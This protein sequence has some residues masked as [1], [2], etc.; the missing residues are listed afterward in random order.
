MYML[1]V[2]TGI[3]ATQI[4][5]KSAYASSDG[6][7]EWLVMVVSG[8][9][10]RL[11]GE[12][13]SSQIPPGKQPPPSHEEVQ[14]RWED[15]VWHSTPSDLCRVLADIKEEATSVKL[16]L[17]G[18]HK[19]AT[20]SIKRL[21]QQKEPQVYSQIAWAITCGIYAPAWLAAERAVKVCPP[22][23]GDVSSTAV[24]KL[25]AYCQLCTDQARK[26]L[27]DIQNAAVAPKN[28]AEELHEQI[29][30]V[31]REVN[32]VIEITESPQVLGIVKK[33]QIET[34]ELVGDIVRARTEERITADQARERL[35]RILGEWQG[36]RLAFNQA[37]QHG[38]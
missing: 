13:H 3:T 16:T 36:I 6:Q 29:G 14:K 37:I 32:G 30:L 22:V 38:Q 33:E 12:I 23:D 17:S 25:F 8:A 1:A 5:T 20:N 4:I 9:S 24:Q 26:Q 31:I 18:R 11:R 7:S 34:R 15:L 35:T 2:I 21:I 27:M 19:I 10:G 28:V